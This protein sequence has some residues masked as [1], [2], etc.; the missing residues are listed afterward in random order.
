MLKAAAVLAAGILAG[1]LFVVLRPEGEDGAPSAATTEATTGATTSE[2]TATDESTTA[3]TAP[4]L[5]RIV[6]E[7]R[8]GRPVGG[9]ARVEVERGRRVQLV[10]TS[11]VADHVHVHGHDLFA[12]V[13]PGQPA[14]FRF[15]ATIPGRIE[16]EL[17]DRHT[18]L[19]ELSVRP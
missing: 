6:I 3:A 13:A 9:V 17:E 19:G 18:L 16:V 5:T 4:Q 7:V 1:A 10:V 8:G 11:D 12:D 14:R 15:R 2:D